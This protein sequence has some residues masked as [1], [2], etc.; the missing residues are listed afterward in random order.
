MTSLLKGRKTQT[1]KKTSEV[2]SRHWLL[3]AVILWPMCYHTG[4]PCRR[5]RTWHP[6]LS[7]YTDIEPTC[8]CAIYWC[9]TSHWNTP[10]PTRHNNYRKIII[11]KH[12]CTCFRCDPDFFKYFTASPCVSTINGNKVCNSEESTTGNVCKWDFESRDVNK[13]YCKCKGASVRSDSCPS[14]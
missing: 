11:Y 8:R 13:F 6:T 5:H 12:S 4:M 9:G 7:Q 14:K 1:N 10:L 2:I 3:V